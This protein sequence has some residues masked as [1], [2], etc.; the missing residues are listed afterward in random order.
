MKKVTL[1]FSFNKI[2]YITEYTAI[3]II[4]NSTVWRQHICLKQHSSFECF[5]WLSVTVVK[6]L[7]LKKKS[8]K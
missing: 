7:W 5:L 6:K 8:G 2:C 1:Y 3:Y 4:L